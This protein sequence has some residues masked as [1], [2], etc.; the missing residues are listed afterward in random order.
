MCKI[1][2]NS[3]AGRC[4][5]ILHTLEILPPCDYCLLPYKKEHLW[6][7]LF[8]LEDYVNTAVNASLHCLS[9]HDYSAAMDCT[10]CRCEKCVNNACDYIEY[11]AHMQTFRTKN[12]AILL[13]YYNQIIHKTSD[14]AHVLFVHACPWYALLTSVNIITEVRF[15]IFKLRASLP[16][17]L[18]SHFTVIIH[19]YLLAVNFN[20][21]WGTR[22]WKSNHTTYLFTRLSF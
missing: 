20:W 3:G 12:N 5:Y 16:D 22:P 18:Q 17:I 8:E 7:K 6:G 15:T 14:M 11:R 10:L 9:K 1:W 13:S 21:G 19:V 2:C 4:W